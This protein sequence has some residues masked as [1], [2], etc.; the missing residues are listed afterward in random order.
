MFAR[1][2]WQHF[3]G[4]KEVVNQ[5]D[6]GIDPHPSASD[7]ERLSHDVA[8][9]DELGVGEAGEGLANLGVTRISPI[10]QSHQRARVDEDPVH[11]SDSP[12]ISS[13][14]MARSPVPESNRPATDIAMRKRD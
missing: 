12:A 3:Y 6:R 11:H 5:G 9:A 4:R 13:C 2:H 1:P 7:R 10:Q 8:M 14:R